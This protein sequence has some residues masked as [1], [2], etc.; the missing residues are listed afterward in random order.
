MTQP[1]RTAVR[2]RALRFASVRTAWRAGA[3][4]APAAAVAALVLTLAC[5]VCSAPAAPAG[6]APRS[7]TLKNGARVLLAPDPRASAVSVGLWVEAGVRYERPGMIG[8]SHLV[9]HLSARGVDPGGDAEV[10]R[11]I[12]ALG[13]SSASF[14]SDDFTCFLDAVPRTGL[15]TVLQ[16]ET[17][18]FAARPTAA[19]LDQDRA[20]VRG[21][22][23]TRMQLNPL[24]RP[25]QELYF[26][27]FPNHPYRF[28]ATGIDQDLGRLSLKDC[29]DYL[30]ARYTPDHLWVTI[31]G[32]F[33]ADQ[34]QELLRRTVESIGG[35]GD[36]RPPALKL[37]ESTGERRQTVAGD[38]PVPIL[39]VGWRVPPDAGDAAALE[40]MAGVLSGGPSSRL[41]LRVVGDQ[42]AC[43]FARA[44]RDRQR[45]A[46]LF[47]AAAALRPG[48][49]S[50]AVEK[51][52]I[53]EIERLATEP[54]PGE[55]LD[56]ARKQLE[57]ALFISR[58]SSADRGQALGMAQMIAGDWQD[59]H[60]E[61][62]R[63]RSLTPADVQQVAA[64]TLTAAR[65]TVVWLRAAPGGGR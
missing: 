2:A 51:N 47:W 27:A 15:E 43:L 29:Q 22:N 6:S 20:A 33:D 12:A 32:D 38:V 14:T 64:R 55:E 65:R 63:L 30:R 31:V 35:K 8:I 60:G 58:E 9:E 41:P 52:L 5:P 16:L 56:R 36:A 37:P 17:R 34:A 62:E 13:G 18:R 50:A 23:Q 59:A 49:D 39:T 21:E 46:T 19:M 57:V 61:L 7:L 54:I 44:S 11:R 24:E 42:Q 25:L 28:P 40:L 48:A 4:L 45:D 53:A 26:A 10:R 3:R 1:R